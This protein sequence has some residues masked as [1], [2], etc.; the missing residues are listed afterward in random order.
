MRTATLP[1]RIIFR[2]QFCTTVPD[3]ETQLTLEHGLR[4]LI[5]GEYLDVP[6]GGWL[7]WHGGGPL[8][9][10]RYA[11]KQHRGELTAYLREHYGTIAPN[12]WAMGPYPITRR[13]PDTEKAIRH[14]GL[15][16][17]PKWG[18]S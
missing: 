5:F 6:P 9:P 2:C 4:E 18:L 17:I 1:T 12:P 16:S 14:G 8:G 15:S 3:E 11:C 7:T 10:R 13:S